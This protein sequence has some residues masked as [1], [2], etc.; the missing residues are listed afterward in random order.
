M[1]YEPT[2][3][4]KELQESFRMETGKEY[5]DNLELYMQYYQGKSLEAIAKSLD[6]IRA[7]LDK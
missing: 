7:K 6:K 4:F 3:Y 1:T 5:L 2:N